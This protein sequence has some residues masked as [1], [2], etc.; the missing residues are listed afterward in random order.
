M[1][2]ARFFR[3]IQD[4]P[5]YADFLQ[6]VLDELK[7]LPPGATVLDMG[8]GAGKLIAMGQ[9][10]PDVQWEGADVD[11]AMLAEARKRP[12]LRHTALHHLSAGSTLPFTDARYEAVTFCSVLFLLSDP[13]PLLEETWRVLR[14]HGFIVALTPSGSGQSRPILRNQIGWRFHNWTWF[15]W[16]QMTAAAGQRWGQQAPLAAFARRH[17][18]TYQ[19]QAVFHEMATIEMVFY[20]ERM[21]V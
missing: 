18:A 4:A 21:P 15:V 14:P 17:G 2:H 6:P 16:R 8:T 3:Y 13:M 10:L 12:A 1:S 9:A 5:W 11:A 7:S 20:G 19:K